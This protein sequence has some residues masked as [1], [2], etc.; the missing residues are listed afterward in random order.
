MDN[1]FDLDGLLEE[2]VDLQ[3][4]AKQEKA[5][6]KAGQKGRPQEK[7]AGSWMNKQEIEAHVAAVQIMRAKS[8][9]W[10]KLAGVL[11]IHAQICSHCGSEHQHVEG[12]FLKRTNPKLRLTNLVKPDGMV[13]IAGL[14]KEIE[15]RTFSAPICSNCCDSQGW[16]EASKTIL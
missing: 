6:L 11:L 12:I 1:D 2:S 13:D 3:K 7:Q 10:V 5:S 9:G 8:E 15:I 4:R 14:P 16:A